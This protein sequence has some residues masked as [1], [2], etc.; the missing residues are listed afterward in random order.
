MA[1]NPLP[2]PFDPPSIFQL[3]C[4][5]AFQ[6]GFGA[7][8]KQFLNRLRGALKISP[9]L[10]KKIAVQAQKKTAGAPGDA[11]FRP[12]L[13]L[14]RLVAH[15][16]KQGIEPQTLSTLQ[17]LGQLVRSQG[18]EAASVPVPPPTPAPV[19]APAP[20]PP[21]PVALPPEPTPPP[22]P[23]AS[24]FAETAPL[25]EV[26][27]PPLPPDEARPPEPPGPQPL[28]D[29]GA[30]FSPPEPSP[31]AATPSEPPVLEAGSP[32]FEAEEGP[33]AAGANPFEDP[34][35]PQEPLAP[36]PPPSDA[37]APPEAGKKLQEIDSG[38]GE[39]SLGDYQAFP[40]AASWSTRDLFQQS[41]DILT[42]NLSY[43]TPMLVGLAAFSLL[44]LI[45]NL[46]FVL[47][48]IVTT[49]SV[50]ELARGG[51]LTSVSATW[52]QWRGSIWPVMTASLASSVLMILSMILGGMGVGAMVFA[53]STGFGISSLAAVAV[54]IFALLVQVR[55]FF[56]GPLLFSMHEAILF[57]NGGFR[58]LKNSEQIASQ[59]RFQ[60]LGLALL[61]GIGLSTM[62]PV[63]VHLILSLLTAPL[64]LALPGAMG[65]IFMKFGV[66][67][68]SNLVGQTCILLGSTFMTLLYLR[69]RSRL[70]IPLEPMPQLP[71]N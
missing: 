51:T 71:P 10:S 38:G 40:Q 70:A 30:S 19:P 43:W 15:A 4:V 23:I 45:G 28:P 16:K 62:V 27:R 11:P 50:A 59:N 66:G 49:G 1:S 44:P 22:S 2:R 69:E 25:E 13:L 33:E 26:G 24:G 68:V 64:M 60:I 57:R 46:L 20:E 7:P 52:Q 31:P 55:V 8:E 17:I 36:P 14:Q 67:F 6:A 3:A 12:K 35:E 54:A 32:P 47:V 34:P 48:A 39:I 53:M 41:L 63:L 42:Q 58:A 29:L 56:G 9:E 65:L 61:A 5:E 37:L 21:P 18:A